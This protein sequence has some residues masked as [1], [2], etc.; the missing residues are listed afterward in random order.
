MNSLAGA[1]LSSDFLYLIIIL[2]LYTD[3]GSKAALLLALHMNLQKL[4]N[5]SLS[6][7]MWEKE[8]IPIA[9]G[10]YEGRGQ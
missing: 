7:L 9:A 1:I 5:L 8:E 3:L 6:F 10:C 2:K 4:F